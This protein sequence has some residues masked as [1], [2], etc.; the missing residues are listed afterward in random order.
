MLA[1]IVDLQVEVVIIASLPTFHGQFPIQNSK[2]TE[3]VSSLR[4]FSIP[5]IRPKEYLSYRVVHLRV[6]WY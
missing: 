1:S 5:F 4:H 2:L 6:V 3:G